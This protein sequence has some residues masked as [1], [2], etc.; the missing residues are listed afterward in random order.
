[1]THE[2]WRYRLRTATAPPTQKLVRLICLCIW[3]HRATH[4]GHAQITGRGEEALDHLCRVNRWTRE[5]AVE[6]VDEAAE[7]WQWH[8]E[9]HWE[10]ELSMV[11]P[12]GVV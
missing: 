9:Q 3:C 10:L 4:Y 5:Q 7:R 11:K 8:S 12:R 2:R 1:L 6:H